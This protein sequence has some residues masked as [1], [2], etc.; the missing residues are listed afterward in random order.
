MADIDL[1]FAEERESAW[2]TNR[3]FPSKIGG[4]P[5]WLELEK[6]PSNKELLCETCQEPKAFLCQ[7][8]APFEDEYNFHRTIYVFVCRSAGCQVS[9]SARHLTVYRSQLPRKNEFYSEEPPI[10][11]GSPLPE[12]QSSKKLCKACGCTGPLACS[13]CRKVNYC[14]A[15]H[16]RSH[17]PHHKKICIAENQSETEN[18][19]ILL[20][21]ISFPEWEI[22]VEANDAGEETATDNDD[23]SV[24][25]KN[26]AE[27]QNLVEAG[28]TGTL[29]DVAESELD[30]YA[31]ES[32]AADDKI[33]R[34]FRKE[35]S[36]NP[37]QVVRYGR[38]GTPLW[39]AD[40]E[41][42]IAQQLQIP[43]CELCGGER[44]FE[45]QIMP[46]MLNL[47]KDDQLD[48]GTLT[49]Y[50]CSKSCRLP[51]DKG[52]VREYIVKQD[53]ISNENKK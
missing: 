9:N 3:Y 43:N 8:Y 50:T 16:Q 51:N 2:L 5:A 44:Q 30:K 24:E 29:K 32:V 35:V 49:L 15:K 52:Y 46:Q 53:I 14:S 13:R 39:I 37:D 17:W 33:F 1:G 42:T 23:G 10:E 11:E 45:Y 47:L 21:N 12:I 31:N 4:K 6:L 40:V 27:Y 38:G 34:K 48:W 26:L 18:T 36:K 41:Q 25:E 28:K 22:V 7:I 20:P 19:N